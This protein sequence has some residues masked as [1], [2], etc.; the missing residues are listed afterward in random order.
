MRSDDLVG[1]S[2]IAELAGVSRQAAYNW[3]TRYPTFPKP[4]AVLHCGTIWSRKRV[5]AWLEANTE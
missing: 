5:R 1:L 4:L 3:T 2:E